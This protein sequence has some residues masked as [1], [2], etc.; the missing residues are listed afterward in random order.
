M[1][2]LTI[3]QKLI[4]AFTAIFLMALLL[5]A[6]GLLGALKISN[7]SK[8]ILN[9]EAFIVNYSSQARALSL[10]LRR[11]EKDSF[12]NINNEKKRK[13][14]IEKWHKKYEELNTV[15]N[16]LNKRL[17]KHSLDED[18]KLV[19]KCI[20]GVHEY[21][22]AFLKI[23]D[24][25]N[26]GLIT[27]PAGGNKALKPFKEY[28][29]D[30]DVSSAALAEK[31]DGIINSV[32]KKIDNSLGLVISSIAVLLL[33]IIISIAVISFLLMRA[34]NTPIS[35][36]VKS[37]SEVAKGDFRKKIIVDNNDEFGHIAKASESMR[38]EISKLIIDMT[39]QIDFLN[40]NASTMS[41][42]VNQTVE[43]S[44]Q[45]SQSIVH[46]S[47]SATEQNEFV[48]EVVSQ[49]QSISNEL[50]TISDK[51]SE[52]VDYSENSKNNSQQAENEAKEAILKFNNLNNLSLEATN[53][54]KVLGKKVEEISVI[55][56]LI[57]N[58]SSQTNLLALNASI[59]AARA[60][61]QGKG[62]A[63]VAEEVKKLAEESAKASNQI[64]G[65]INEIQEKTDLSIKCIDEN[66]KEIC[67]S[68]ELVNHIS[69]NLDQVLIDS[70]NI[71]HNIINVSD[72]IKNITMYSKNIE[73]SIGKIYS[74]FEENTVGMEE[75]S[76]ISEE[77][78]A[79][80]NEVNESITKLSNLATKVKESV[81]FFKV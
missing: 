29:R 8:N 18:T 81:V 57:K 48:S 20:S 64:T 32:H 33:I 27:T 77:Q 42:S 40:K 75:V 63:V 73:S 17:A 5:G 45:I 19:N 9:K 11:C 76:A 59:E 80:M 12:L 39:S 52:I 58:I 2:S 22:K 31:Y 55:I 61:E 6:A 4:L 30:V 14:Y 10:H 71:N 54:I 62:F 7:T 56:E 51:I 60:G 38:N 53:T 35:Q 43:G 34:I 50:S 37:L 13:K 21:K 24:D 25:I 16:K 78:V 47:T 49:S 70:N 69:S 1:K 28:I 66:D 72:V 23:Q 79:N 36:L 26:A 67:K 46:L 15:L 3:V 68:S 41:T 74:T 65:M 44:N